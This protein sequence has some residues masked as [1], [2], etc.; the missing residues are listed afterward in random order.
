MSYKP[1]GYC[2]VSPYLVVNGAGQTIAFLMEVF[3]ASVLRQ[4]AGP[5]GTILHA[6]VRLDDSVLMLTDGGPGFPP[7]SSHVHVYVQDVD[8]VYKRAIEAGASSV[9]EPMKKGDENKRGAVRDTGG[10]TWWIATKVG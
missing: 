1:T 8:R 3:G 9:Q 6:E 2:T 4:F 7:V 5:E 10:T